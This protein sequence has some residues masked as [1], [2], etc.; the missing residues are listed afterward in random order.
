MET[1]KTYIDHLLTLGKPF[2]TKEEAL[3]VVFLN[4]NQYKLQM[5]RLSQKGMIKRIIGDFYIII[6]PEYRSQGSLPVHWFI[7]ALMKHRGQ[8]YYIG[9]LSAAS[10]YGATN[11]QPMRFQVITTK[12]IR[13]IKLNGMIIEFHTNKY[14]E[15]AGIIA[16][17]VPTG[18]V[19]IS[20]K[21]QTMLDL[22]QFYQ[23]VGYLDNVGSIVKALANEPTIKT[24]AEEEDLAN[25]LKK[26]IKNEHTNSVLQR[27]GYLFKFLRLNE[28]AQMIEDKLSKRR[29]EYILL[30]PESPHKTGQKIPRWKI[31]LND[32][33]DIE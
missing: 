26:V 15:L 30:K 19:K 17:P 14:C 20:N 16:I 25:E 28:F 27:L 11:Q 31:I 18:Y 10:F 24:F 33:L 12:A 23:A 32:A 21:A 6:S 3:K 29:I 9:L 4:D 8:F 1:L 13:P 2:F 7:D 22:V 5:Y